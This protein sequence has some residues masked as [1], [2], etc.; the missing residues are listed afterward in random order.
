MTL[1][2]QLVVRRLVTMAGSGSESWAAGGGNWE[3]EKSVFVFSYRLVSY[4]LVSCL[5]L[6][7]WKV[8]TQLEIAIVSG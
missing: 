4:R 7:L 8:W 3:W 6:M 1:W 5:S 2:T